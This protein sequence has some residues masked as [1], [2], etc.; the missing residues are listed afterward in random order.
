M[1]KRSSMLLVLATGSM[2]VLGACELADSSSDAPETVAAAP[3]TV[4]PTAA[5]ATP[6]AAPAEVEAP[7]DA[8]P[9]VLMPDVVCVDLQFAQD[10][11]QTAGV[12]LSRSVDATGQG[13][14]QVMD[15][16]WTVV[17]QEP[18]AGTPIGEGEAV[19]S[20]VKDNEPNDC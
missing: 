10:T 15:R 16:N 9:T 19:L 17:G 4:A 14:M 5:G 3:G 7:D 6:T 13:R 1:N 12:W 11:I 8:E 20:V 18:A 2:L